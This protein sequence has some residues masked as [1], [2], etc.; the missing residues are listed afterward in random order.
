MSC[1]NLDTKGF[2]GETKLFCPVCQKQLTLIP[3][4]TDNFYEVILVKDMVIFSPIFTKYHMWSN[5]AIATIDY[6]FYLYLLRYIKLR[7]EYMKKPTA[8][9]LERLKVEPSAE[10]LPAVCKM[11]PLDNDIISEV[12]HKIEEKGCIHG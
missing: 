3:R 10:F 8:G 7:Y 2:C 9:K 11:Y 4:H 5:S 12:L 1:E 6:E